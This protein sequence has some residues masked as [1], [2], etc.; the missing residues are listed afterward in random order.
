MRLNKALFTLTP[1]QLSRLSEK[2]KEIEGKIITLEIESEE[3]NAGKIE[4]L[5]DRKDSLEIA[6]G[7]YFEGNANEYEIRYLI[8]SL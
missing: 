3:I 2:V 5:V 4:R 7:H 6:L 1:S 8:A